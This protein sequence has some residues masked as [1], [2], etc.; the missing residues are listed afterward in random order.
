MKNQGFIHHPQPIHQTQT[1]LLNQAQDA[2]GI[3]HFLHAVI[4]D[5]IA[6][7]LRPGRFSIDLQSRGDLRL[8]KRM[9]ASYLLFV[10]LHFFFPG[11]IRHRF[12]PSL[13]LWGAAAWCL[14]KGSQFSKRYLRL[15]LIENTCGNAR[16]FPFSQ[17]PCGVWEGLQE[18]TSI[19][20][21]CLFH[22]LGR[23]CALPCPVS[24]FSWFHKSKSLLFAS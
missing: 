3:C 1:R 12:S 2:H 13:C 22:L 7:P 6:T 24:S 4:H 9:E 18:Q 15:K 5:M 16:H 10:R 21:C 17:L 20:L 19:S 14:S 23:G 8:K 11:S